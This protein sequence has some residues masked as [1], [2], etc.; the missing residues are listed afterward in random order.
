MV[1]PLPSGARSWINLD[2][3]ND[4]TGGSNIR[5]FGN[6]A[7]IIVIADAKQIKPMNIFILCAQREFLRQKEKVEIN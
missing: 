3:H 5:P 2:A 7:E 1:Y 4:G 6:W